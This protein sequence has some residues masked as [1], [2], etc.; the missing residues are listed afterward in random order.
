MAQ[1][2]VSTTFGLKLRIVVEERRKIIG[3]TL[4]PGNLHDV[5]CAEELLHGRRGIVI[6]DKGYCSERLAKLLSSQGL[7]LIARRK[8]NMIPNSEEK[9][10]LKKRSIIAIVIAKLKNLFDATLTRFRSPQAAFSVIYNGAFAVNF[11]L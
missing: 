8:Q 9:K 2:S 6:W 10:L 11:A 5:T 7:R 3:F 4:K 1:P